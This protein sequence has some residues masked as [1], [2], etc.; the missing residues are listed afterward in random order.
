M[1]DREAHVD[2]WVELRMILDIQS[3]P[4]LDNKIKRTVGDANHN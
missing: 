3:A 2:R 1:D 4:A